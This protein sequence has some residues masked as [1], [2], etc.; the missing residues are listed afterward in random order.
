L[1][2][3]WSDADPYP[4]LAWGYRFHATS[5]SEEMLRAIVAADDRLYARIGSSGPFGLPLYGI[6]YDRN[7]GG[8]ALSD[9]TQFVNGIAVTGPSDGVTAIDP[10]DSYAE[11]WFDAFWALF[12][13]ADDPYDTGQWEMGAG[14]ISSRILIDGDWDGLSFAAAAPTAPRLPI[15]AV[16]YVATFETAR[17]GDRQSPRPVPEWT[18]ATP[19]CWLV[20]AWASGRRR[21]QR[22]ATVGAPAGRS[23]GGSSMS[24]G[25]EAWPAALS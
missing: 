19:W 20:F 18:G 15:A 14:G 22:P 17:R 7:L 13:S 8:F 11:G 6:G 21:R 5:T 16:R 4:P 10:Q 3:D 12:V 9:G 24:F 1:V 23:C 2:V 25:I